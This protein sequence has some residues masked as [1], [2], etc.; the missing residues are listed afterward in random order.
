LWTGHT[1]R[2][3]KDLDLLGWGSSSTIDQAEATIRA[4]CEIQNDDGIVFEN[5]SI[6]GNRIKEQD[7]YD[8]V[9]VKFLAELA[10]ARIPMQIDIGFG[11]AIYPET[12]IL[13][14]PVLLPI[15]WKHPSFAR[16]REKRL[17]RKNSMQWSF[18]IFA[19]AA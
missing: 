9:R 7:E 19:T 17:S 13:S 2:P 14:F 12:E 6:E 18:S 11:D 4:I 16:I 8:G 15:L 1:H 3:T 10:K 5:E